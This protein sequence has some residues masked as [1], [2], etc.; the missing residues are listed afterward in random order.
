MSYFW[1]ML[2]GSQGS[3]VILGAL[4]AEVE[5]FLSH[6]DN[7]QLVQG[8]GLTAQVGTLN[9]KEVV[10]C[11][12]GV[13]KVYAAMTTQ[14]LI[15]QFQPSAVLFTGVA[16]ALNP[17]YDVGD[18]VL[19]KD[20]VQY[21][22]DARGLGFSVGTI[23]YTDLRFFDCDAKLLQNAQ[24]T[25]TDHKI[26]VGRILTGDRFVTH[27]YIAQLDEL[28]LKFGG[29]AVEMEGAAVAQVCT[30]HQIP[31]LIIRTISD[32]ANADSPI[33]FPRFLPIVAHNSF[34]VIEQI[35]GMEK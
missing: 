33:D 17:S 24:L 14:W 13:G 27:E 31:F 11:K 25:S 3:V 5:A 6:M 34:A 19:A 10:V 30:I 32:K 18:I 1:D 7:K 8:G 28:K 12:S 23:P 22:M 35:L 26:H 9:G 16:G 4:D 29:D 15:Q 20:C 2:I 21:D